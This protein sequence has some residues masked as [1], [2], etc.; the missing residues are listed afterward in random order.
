MCRL[1]RHAAIANQERD[2]HSGGA[3]YALLT[4]DQDIRSTSKRSIDVVAG[5]LEVGFQVSGTGIEDIDAITID[6]VLFGRREPRDLEDLDEGGDAVFAQELAIVDGCHRTDVEG[7]SA[8]GC[9]GG[10][11][12]GEDEV[13]RGTHSLHD[14]GGETVETN[15]DCRD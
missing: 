5:G 2:H 11:G 10:R 6:A 15:H 13:H 9:G 1:V 4:V 14:L 8:R 12:G 3:G 7:T